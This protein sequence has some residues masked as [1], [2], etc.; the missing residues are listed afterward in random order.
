MLAKEFLIEGTPFKA[1]RGPDCFSNC[2]PDTSDA[3][4]DRSLVCEWRVDVAP[5]DASDRMVLS[6]GRYRGYDLAHGERVSHSLVVNS[7]MDKSGF[8]N[9]YTLFAPY[10]RHTLAASFHVAAGGFCLLD[11]RQLKP[12]TMALFTQRTAPAP[13]RGHDFLPI[14]EAVTADGPALKLPCLRRGLWATNVHAHRPQ[15]RPAYRPSRAA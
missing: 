7:G 11:M 13:Y 4:E 14:I 10:V 15:N 6:Y 8:I 1:I 3:L 12:A 5:I 9:F 2:Y